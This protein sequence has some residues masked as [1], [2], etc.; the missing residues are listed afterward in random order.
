MSQPARPNS[1]ASIH[2]PPTFP[3]RPS[4]PAVPRG[5]AATP[6]TLRPA[7]AAESPSCFTEIWSTISS[8]VSSI[9]SLISSL[10]NCATG[11]CIDADPAAAPSQTTPA[12]P[13]AD[14]LI[15]KAR[16]FLERRVLHDNWRPQDHSK[17]ALL[18]TLNGNTVGVCVA[19]IGVNTEGGSTN[20]LRALCNQGMLGLEGILRRQTLNAD[21]IMQL[22]MR[23]LSPPTTITNPTGD[24]SVTVHSGGSYNVELS[25]SRDLGHSTSLGSMEDAATV[26]QGIFS[27]IRCDSSEHQALRENVFRFFTNP[28]DRQAGWIYSI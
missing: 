14:V 23:V 9:F 24:R 8:I 26:A 22:R 10:W 13:P 28:S 6:S 27:N 25:A 18:I 4:A 2:T 20:P 15:A 1:L 17:V 16:N 3:T 21:S 19:T 12:L 11:G 7:A 5:I